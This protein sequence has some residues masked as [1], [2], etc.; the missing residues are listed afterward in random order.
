MKP[1]KP[2][3]AN[4][5]MNRLSDAVGRSTVLHCCTASF[6]VYENT[7]SFFTH[8][9]ILGGHFVDARLST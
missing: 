4:P 7:D 3:F 8:N 1:K 9:G 2:T 5:D 6:Y